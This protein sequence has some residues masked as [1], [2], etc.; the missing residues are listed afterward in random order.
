M[1]APTR[2]LKP[3]LLLLLLA[4]PWLAN[5]HEVRPAY[6]EITENSA[7]RVHVLWKQPTA[8]R[9]SLPLKPRLSSGWLDEAATSSVFTESYLLRRW[10]IPAPVGALDGQTLTVEGL[11]RTITDVL[12][13]IAFA[14]GDT[15]DHLLKPD[16][17][18]LAIAHEGQSSLPV[19][20][21]FQLGVTHIWLGIDHLLYVFGLMLLVNG[22]KTLLKT[23]T[24]F[25]V[26]HS[27]TLAGAALG[28]VDLSPRPIE[29]VIAL[30]IVY[31][32]VELVYLHRGR[33]GFA[34]RYP[35]AV[36]FAFGLLHGFGFAGA[37]AEV[38]LPTDA[39]PLA[40]LLFNLGIEAGQVAFVLAVL[41]SLKGIAALLPR[42][43][44]WVPRTAPH[45]IGTLAAFWCLERL[46]FMF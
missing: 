17:P 21:Y 16:H 38:G 37:L 24:A 20:D 3:A 33:P 2:W 41:L 8:G 19:G 22:M 23:I 10:E 29:A 27:I 32:A 1:S 46:E 18:S 45:A 34:C 42:A 14:D 28:Y 12:V 35:W 6:L 44:A 31:V 9:L 5:A 30:S 25:T 40:L 4:V 39:I 15:R 43:A 11:D 26:A 36:A 7:G 13:R